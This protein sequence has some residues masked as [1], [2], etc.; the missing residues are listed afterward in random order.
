MVVHTNGMRYAT[1]GKH[2]WWTTTWERA[3]KRQDSRLIEDVARNAEFH[4]KI[5]E[6]NKKD[7]NNQNAIFNKIVDRVKK[8]HPEMN[9]IKARNY[10]RKKIQWGANFNALKIVGTLQTKLAKDYMDAKDGLQREGT[11]TN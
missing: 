2:A 10:A 11:V 7:F 1:S 6:S 3:D 4:T 8:Q 9:T 5:T